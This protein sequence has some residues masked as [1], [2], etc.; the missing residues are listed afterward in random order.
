MNQLDNCLIRFFGGAMSFSCSKKGRTALKGL[1]R[2][3]VLNA[4]FT[5]FEMMTATTFWQK[6]AVFRHSLPIGKSR[7]L[8]STRTERRDKFR[9]LC[10]ALSAKLVAGASNEHWIPGSLFFFT[11]T[12]QVN[13]LVNRLVS[14]N[15]NLGE[16]LHVPFLALVPLWEPITKQNLK[17]VMPFMIIAMILA[18]MVTTRRYIRRQPWPFRPVASSPFQQH[19]YKGLRASQSALGFGA[20]VLKRK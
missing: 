12:H 4:W 7:T 11:K 8:T 15:W 18:M 10:E 13:H 1:V 5:V 6:W 20:S 19:P 16:R 14:K 9:I 3:K 17:A 2:K